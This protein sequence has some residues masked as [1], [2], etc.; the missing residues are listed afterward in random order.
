MCLHIFTVSVAV[1]KG[2]NYAMICLNFGKAFNK[3]VVHQRLLNKGRVHRMDGRAL[4]WIVLW[5]C[6]SNKL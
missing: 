5:L 2:G 6:N 4:V 1:N 3:A